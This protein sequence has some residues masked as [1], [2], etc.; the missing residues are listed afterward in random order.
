MPKPVLFSSF[1]NVASMLHL[2]LLRWGRCHEGDDETYEISTTNTDRCAHK[3][4]SSELSMF[5]A[6]KRVLTMI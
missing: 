2:N 6:T 4:F 3:L 1:E 5:A